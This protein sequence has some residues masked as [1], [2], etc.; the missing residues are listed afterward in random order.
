MD[1]GQVGSSSQHEDDEGDQVQ[2]GEH[3]R[4]ALVVSC[5]PAAARHPGEASFH[6]PSARQQHEAAL[7]Q[8]DDLQGDAVRL[9]RFGRALA[10]V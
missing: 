1:Q 5:Q 8:A 7:G 10:R 2:P 3:V 9:G 4:Q 6:H